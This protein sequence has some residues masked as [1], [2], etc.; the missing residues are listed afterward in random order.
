MRQIADE[1][2]NFI[3]SY[4]LYVLRDS[5]GVALNVSYSPE[6]LQ[7]SAGNDGKMLS[8][9]SGYI[10]RGTKVILDPT[11]KGVIELFRPKNRKWKKA[12]MAELSAVRRAYRLLYTPNRYDGL[13]IYGRGSRS[14]S[15]F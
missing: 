1:A 9:Q 14:S 4:T 10:S 11:P 5:S 7:W 3:G 12:Q 15:I 13:Q 2:I 8:V 6:G